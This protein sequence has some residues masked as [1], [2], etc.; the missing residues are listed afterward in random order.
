MKQ[1]FLTV[2]DVLKEA[3]ISRNTLY[4]WERNRKI[5]RPKRNIYGH[6]VYS[7]EDVE[8]IVRFTRTVFVPI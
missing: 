6:R 2:K 7:A 5:P 8:R 3:G 4:H 1:E